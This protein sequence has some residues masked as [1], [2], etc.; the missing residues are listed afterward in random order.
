MKA[1]L[2]V[3]VG[4]LLD[5]RASTIGLVCHIFGFLFVM[6]ADKVSWVIKTHG[7]FFYRIC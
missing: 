2:A 3:D 1:G 7:H 5:F 4:F 6:V